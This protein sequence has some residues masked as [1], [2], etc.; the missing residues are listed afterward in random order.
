MNASTATLDWNFCGGVM[1]SM[2]SNTKKDD[3]FFVDISSSDYSEQT[4]E[5]K[6]YLGHKITEEITHNKK[7]L[8]QILKAEVR[9][10][11]GDLVEWD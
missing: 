2:L 4:I 1:D 7:L 11:K 6:I 10:D 8:K 3:S 5:E 9:A